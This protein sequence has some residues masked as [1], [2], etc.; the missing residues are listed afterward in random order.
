ML[1]L[2]L[3]ELQEPVVSF[4]NFVSSLLNPAIIKNQII[5]K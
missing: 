2:A 1:E 5:I 3:T 4:R